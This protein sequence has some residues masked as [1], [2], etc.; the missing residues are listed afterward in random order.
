MTI[1]NPTILSHNAVTM[2]SSTDS[3]NLNA[4]AANTLYTVPVGKKCCLHHVRLRNISA[5]CTSAT[6]TVGQ[7]GALADFLSTRTLSALNAAASTGILSPVP[8]TTPVKGIEYTAG[9]IIQID[10]PIAAGI[11]CTAT[12]ELFGTLDNA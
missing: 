9:E 1:N 10:V 7:V 2:L 11:A 6:C 8:N 3:V 12:V 5:N 4:V